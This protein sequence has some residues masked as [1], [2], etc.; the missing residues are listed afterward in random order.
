MI[1]KDNTQLATPRL[2]QHAA[3]QSPANSAGRLHHDLQKDVVCAKWLSAILIPNC[4]AEIF[5]FN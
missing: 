1:S 5:T 4:M 2:Y 3:M